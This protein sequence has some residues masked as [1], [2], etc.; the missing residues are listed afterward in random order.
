MRK[1]LTR[2]DIVDALAGDDVARSATIDEILRDEV[3]A[4]TAG[5]VLAGLLVRPGGGRGGV[6]PDEVAQF[7]RLLA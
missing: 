7:R 2:T 5:G 4:A 3:G 6:D 1:T